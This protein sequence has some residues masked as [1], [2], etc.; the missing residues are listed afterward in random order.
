MA[1]AQKLL[2]TWTVKHR[3]V[4]MRLTMAPSQ[5]VVRQ[6]TLFMTK[7]TN[8]PMTLEPAEMDAPMIDASAIVI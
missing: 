1:K 8:G 5:D 2:D 3:R 7:P 6:P 4:E